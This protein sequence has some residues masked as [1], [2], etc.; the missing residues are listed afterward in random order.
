MHAPA[1]PAPMMHT[2]ARARCPRMV[3]MGP[4]AG[5]LHGG[6]VECWA[7]ATIALI[8]CGRA[9]KQRP[10]GREASS[11]RGARLNPAGRPLLPSRPQVEGVHLRGR[12]HGRAGA[13]TRSPGQSEPPT[14]PPTNPPAA[15][16]YDDEAEGLLSSDQFPDRVSLL[17]GPGGKVAPG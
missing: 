5:P 6:R 17:P 3:P 16:L 12:E 2:S 10:A 14:P 4:R 11:I 8:R 13:R 15:R 7:G 9:M 1:T